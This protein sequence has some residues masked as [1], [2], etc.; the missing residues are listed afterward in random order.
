VE[1]LQ[2][3]WDAPT[4]AFFSTDVVIGHDNDGRRYH[5]FKCAAKPCK[6]QRPVRRYLDKG[7][8]QSTS[9][10]RKHAKRCWGEDTVELAD[11][12]R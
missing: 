2:A 12:D 1:R 7:D 6:T 3:A 11:Y 10:L 8:A 9:N 5:E 4:Y